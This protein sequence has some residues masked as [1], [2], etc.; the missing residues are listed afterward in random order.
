MN[1]VHVRFQGVFVGG[2]VLT[3]FTLEQFYS[4]MEPYVGQKANLLF[5]NSWTLITKVL[6]IEMLFLNGVKHSF[7]LTEILYNT[8]NDILHNPLPHNETF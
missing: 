3:L 4:V 7:N 1:G 6:P 8:Y 5:V 2:G